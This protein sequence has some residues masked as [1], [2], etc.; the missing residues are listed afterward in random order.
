ML[1]DAI[2]GP[3]EEMVNHIADQSGQD[4]AGP[5]GPSHPTGREA[6]ACGGSGG[7]V[8]ALG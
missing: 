2:G 4:W 7:E 3:V 5:S 6:E 8:K 1:S